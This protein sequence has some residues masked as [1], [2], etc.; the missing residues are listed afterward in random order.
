[1][2]EHW[3]PMR[4]DLTAATMDTLWAV[5]LDVHSVDRKAVTWGLS[6]AASKD[7]QLVDCW[8]ALKVSL[9]AVCWETLKAGHWVHWKVD[10]KAGRTEHSSV[11]LSAAKRAES[12]AVN[13]AHWMASRWA[14]H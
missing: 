10:A 3:E 7:M 14:V 9:W 13:L 5:Y 11:S 6:K 2:A 12:K 1:M 8:A 4:V